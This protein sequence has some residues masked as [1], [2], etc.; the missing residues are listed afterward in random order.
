M[1]FQASSI[2]RWQCSW[3]RGSSNCMGWG[4]ANSGLSISQSWRMEVATEPSQ[5]SLEVMTAL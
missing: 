3:T 4:M 1:N 5:A 2:S